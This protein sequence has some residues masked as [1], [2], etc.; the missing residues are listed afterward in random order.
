MLK[1]NTCHFSFS[2]LK[3]AVL[4]RL[5][6]LNITDEIRKEFA[7]ELEDTIVEILIKKTEKALDEHGAKSLIIG[8]GVIA[9][10]EI[11]KAFLNLG[12]ER[13]LPILIPEK[14][15][16]TDNAIMIGIAGYFRALKNPDGFD[17]EKIEANGNLSL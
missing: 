13:N 2:G 14:E 10:A 9:N 11:R 15:V 16:S 17:I 12:T 4:Y 7:R 6:E 5:K 8:G 1:D 3:T